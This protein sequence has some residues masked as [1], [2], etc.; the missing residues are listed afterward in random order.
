MIPEKGS[1]DK[2]PPRSRDPHVEIRSGISAYQIPIFPGSLEGVVPVPDWE[3]SSTPEN[4]DGSGSSWV[5]KKNSSSVPKR[6]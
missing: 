2:P 5:Q 6:K 1:F 4:P 3:P